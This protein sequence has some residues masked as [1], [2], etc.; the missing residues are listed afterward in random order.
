MLS[1]SQQF[2][3]YRF[4]PKPMAHA[5]QGLSCTSNPAQMARGGPGDA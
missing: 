5:D 3:V 2:R 4:A 1:N